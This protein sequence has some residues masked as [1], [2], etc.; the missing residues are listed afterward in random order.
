MSAPTDTEVQTAL[1]A[2]NQA[3]DNYNY[4]VEKYSN[5]G[6]I[7]RLLEGTSN[8]LKLSSEALNE[9]EG[10]YRLLAG[11]GQI[12]KPGNSLLP[13]IAV[14]ATALVMIAIFINYLKQ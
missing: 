5:S 7:D 12:E 11:L 1:I 13:L 9:A 2:Y 6:F 14:S 8:K 4:W 3:Q 10:K